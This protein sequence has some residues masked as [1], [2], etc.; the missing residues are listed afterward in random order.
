MTVYLHKNDLPKNI[1][2]SFLKKEI[3]IDTET[4]GL[5][6]LRDRLCLIQLSE[7]NDDA[8]LVQFDK[9]NYSSP[10]LK[11]LLKNK[12]TVKIM[13]FARFDIGILEKTFKTKVKNVY[14]TKIASKI[15]R[16]YSSAHGLKT[17]IKEFL[18]I[19]ISKKEQSSYWGNEK[20]TKE[21]LNYAAADVLYLHEIK[22]N[23]EKILKREN[24]EKLAKNCMKFLNTRVR[25]DLEGW[26]DVDIFSHS[27]Q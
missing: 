9:N 21:Q 22:N 8:H 2:E 26:L 15:A 17:L 12:D 24:R 6:N 13:H 3:A 20:I 16:T 11:K 14:C 25:L 10:N 4:L 5:N 27:S 18:N 7:G 19:D 23:L 1:L